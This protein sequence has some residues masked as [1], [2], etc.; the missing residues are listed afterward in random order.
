MGDAFYGVALAVRPVVGGIDAPAVA[1]AEMRGV[2]D[3]V[4]HRVAHQHVLMRHVYLGPQYPGAV[5]EVT[6]PHPPQQI[7]VLVGAAVAPRA[8]GAGGAE[9][10]PCS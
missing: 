3:P 10:P 7:Q 8:L 4:H 1:G 2:A 9:V 6:G 5:G